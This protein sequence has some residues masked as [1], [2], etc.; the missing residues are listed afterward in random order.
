MW[1]ALFYAVG[2]VL[3]ALGV[4]C[5]IV[6]RFTIS[7]AARLPEFIDRIFYDNG[8]GGYGWGNNQSVGSVASPQS[9]QGYGGVPNL[10]S[11]Y[12]PSRFGGSQFGNDQ[13]FGGG[14]QVGQA[15]GNA[16]FSLAGFGT[17]PSNPMNQQN[18]TGPLKVVQ[19]RDWMPWSLIAAGTV[20]VLY[21]NS[22]GRRG[23]ETE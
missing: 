17:S 18:L 7:Q 9:I 1:R 3:I 4:E 5:I 20:I 6:G 15:T 19:T 13:F 22:L 21:T 16:P 14:N 12:G 2:I 23:G 8:P 11:R 10:S